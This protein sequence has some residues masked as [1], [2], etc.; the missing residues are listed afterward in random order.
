VG[1]TGLGRAFGRQPEHSRIFRRSLEAIGVHLPDFISCERTDRLAL[2]TESAMDLAFLGLPSGASAQLV[3]IQG[4]VGADIKRCRGKQSWS[5]V[6]DNPAL[7]QKAAVAAKCFGP[8][9]RLQA[10][11]HHGQRFD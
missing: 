1:I 2:S 7:G 4:S 10:A 11:A 9:G 3:L 5:T 8:A 6:F